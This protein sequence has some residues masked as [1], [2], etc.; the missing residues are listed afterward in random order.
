MLLKMLATEDRKQRLQGMESKLVL[1]VVQ[2]SKQAIP[3]L[4]VSARD[5]GSIM[6][7]L[8]FLSCLEGKWTFVEATLRKALAAGAHTPWSSFCGR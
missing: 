6:T 7:S 3:C 2:E 1:G 8:N 5:H 4:L